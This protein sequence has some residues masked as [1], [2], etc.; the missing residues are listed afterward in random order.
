MKLGH[1]ADNRFHEVLAKLA[2]APLPL[3]VAF[4]LKGIVKVVR[5]EHAKYEE[6][7]KE[8]LMKYGA[9]NEDGTLKQD[10]KGNVTLEGEGAKAFVSELNELFASEVQVA[11]IKLSELGDDIHMTLEEI[12][13]LEGII[14]D[15]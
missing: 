12:E 5:D 14:V 15:G 7:R 3:K 13:L 9:K 8:A 6:V 2:N 4:K 11:S 10:E 1:I